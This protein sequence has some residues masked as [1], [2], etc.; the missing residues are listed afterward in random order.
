MPHE[1]R[2]QVLFVG[3]IVREAFENAPSALDPFSCFFILPS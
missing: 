1:P 3:K 2:L